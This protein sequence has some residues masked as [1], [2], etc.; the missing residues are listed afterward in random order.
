MARDGSTSFIA[1]MAAIQPR[2]FAPE[3]ILNIGEN[4]NSLIEVNDSDQ[5]SITTYTFTTTSQAERDG[6][7]QR[8]D[9]ESRVRIA[10]SEFSIA[11]SEL[12]QLEWVAGQP[13]TTNGIRLRVTDSQG[14]SGDWSTEAVSWS[15]ANSRLAIVVDNSY[16]AWLNGELLGENPWSFESPTDF[17]DLNLQPGTH[18][19]A[20]EASDAGGPAAVIA[21]LTRGTS[22]L[23]TSRSWRIATEEAEGWQTLDFNDSAWGYAREYDSGTWDFGLSREDFLVPTAK[24]I[25]DADLENTDKA[26]LRIRFEIDTNGQIVEPPTPPNKAPIVTVQPWNFNPDEIVNIGSAFGS[27]FSVSDPE[28]DAIIE[29]EFFDNNLSTVSGNFYRVSTNERYTTNQFTIKAED[30]HDLEWRAGIT[31]SIDG[32]RLK[33]TDQYGATNEWQAENAIWR[34]R[35]RLSINSPVVNE[36][37]LIIFTLSRFDQIDQPLRLWLQVNSGLDKVQIEN[38]QIRELIQS[39]KRIPLDFNGGVSTL[40]LDFFRTRFNVIIETENYSTLDVDI[41]ADE[42]GGGALLGSI[43]KAID[44]TSSLQQPQIRLASIG[45]SYAQSGIPQSFQDLVEIIPDPENHSIVAYTIEDLGLSEGSGYF[46]FNN[47][48]VTSQKIFVNAED[49]SSLKWVP[50]RPGSEED[51]V[52]VLAYDEI[53]DFSETVTTLLSTGKAP[54][55]YK[56]ESISGY[57]H[58]TEGDSFDIRITRYDVNQDPGSASCQWAI[59]D[60]QDEITGGR[61]DFTNVQ[62]DWNTINFGPDGV[63]SSVISLMTKA[64]DITGNKKKVK[65][66]SETVRLWFYNPDVDNQSSDWL[67]NPAYSFFDFQIHDTPHY[68][69]GPTP[70]NVEG[71]SSEM[72]ITRFGGGDEMTKAFLKAESLV[73]TLGSKKWKPGYAMSGEDFKPLA[74]EVKFTKDGINGA[75]TYSV[76][77]ENNKDDQNDGEVFSW[78]LYGRDP[79]IRLNKNGKPI[80]PPKPLD[81]RVANIREAGQR[82]LQ[83]IDIGGAWNSFI[84]WGKRLLGYSKPSSPNALPPTEGKQTVRSVGEGLIGVSNGYASVNSSSDQFATAVGSTVKSIDS[85]NVISTRAVTR[86]PGKPLVGNDPGSALPKTGAVLQGTDLSGLVGNDSAS[87]VGNDSASYVPGIAGGAL[88]AN[89][90]GNLIANGGGNLIANGGGN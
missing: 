67:D 81:Y 50:G 58:V 77:L 90:G 71:E 57:Q 61:S 36:G 69:M 70:T 23:T 25:W 17:F 12:N 74:E 32:I 48:R 51:L 39:G 15:T 83:R 14:G 41:Y 28:G 21:A 13:G 66:G 30:L 63:A 73:E 3:L 19:L 59:F 52:T 16:K 60:P 55:T 37:E 40:N 2:V 78:A 53:G 20:I 42:Q 80:A 44:A 24:W 89:G 49:L 10:A 43:A 26:Y 88:I 86:L 35:R 64:D 65:E 5:G 79:A 7:F 1:T 54:S 76:T 68:V 4:L 72:T 18:V 11:A 87:L 47:A 46:T 45:Y 22:A 33:A 75:K 82:S 84:E 34:S 56:L 38:T 62:S 27:L 8:I 29:Y 9:G 31:N 85:G 6:Y